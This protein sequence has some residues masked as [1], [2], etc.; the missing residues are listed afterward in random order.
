MIVID[1]REMWLANHLSCRA[2]HSFVDCV[3][4]LFRFKLQSSSDNRHYFTL[5]GLFRGFLAVFR[6]HEVTRW[7]ISGYKRLRRRKRR[8]S[9]NSVIGEQLVC[10]ICSWSPRCGSPPQLQLSLEEKDLKR[11]LK[12]Y[13]MIAYKKVRV[14]SLLAIEQ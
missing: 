13:Q 12:G 1:Y 3:S 7:L 6:K 5:Q 2:I 9:E 10:E 4:L 8:N 14:C 11:F